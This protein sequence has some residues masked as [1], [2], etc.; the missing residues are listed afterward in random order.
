MSGQSFL[1]LHFPFLPREWVNV[2]WRWLGRCLLL[3]PSAVFISF[4]FLWSPSTWLRCLRLGF[5]ALHSFRW[6]FS[7]WDFVTLSKSFTSKSACLSSPWLENGFI[8][9]YRISLLPLSL[10]HFLPC[11]CPGC[12][13][14]SYHPLTLGFPWNWANL[15]V[16]ISAWWP[17]V[18]TLSSLSISP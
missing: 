11:C 16:F 13:S 9:L 7:T 8:P 18:G 15:S 5:V 1:W 2:F 4:L 17:M 10:W 12:S 6:M 14:F 3:S